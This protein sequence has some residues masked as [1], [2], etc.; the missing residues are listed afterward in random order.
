MRRGK[1]KNKTPPLRRLARYPWHWPK[2]FLPLNKARLIQVKSNKISNLTFECYLHYNTNSYLKEFH[3]GQWLRFAFKFQSTGGHTYVS[4]M[5][6]GGLPM[7]FAFDIRL[8]KSEF[9]GRFLCGQ[10]ELNN[11]WNS[12]GIH[13]S[14]RNGRFRE[15]QLLI[16]DYFGQLFLN[17]FFTLRHV[18]TGAKYPFSFYPRLQII[19]GKT[20]MA[21]LFADIII[22]VW[23]YCG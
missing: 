4:Q 18:W 22:E 1:L 9:F 10:V 21:W 20:W 17:V 8:A 13:S 2:S 7:Q 15:P 6:T 3:V 23:S 16:L 11:I 19:K 14:T 12:T 5:G